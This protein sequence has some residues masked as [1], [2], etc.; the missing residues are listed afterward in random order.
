LLDRL[1]P[2]LTI[3]VAGVDT[4]GDD[5]LGKLALTDRGLEARERY[6]LACCAARRVPVATVLGGGY[7]DDIDLLAR[8]HAL[9]FRAAA[10]MIAEGEFG[11][12]RARSTVSMS[13]ANPESA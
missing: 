2:D 6:V 7:C 12:A 8:R 13:S 9:V 5:R 11:W 10:E 4:H 1:N 3:Y